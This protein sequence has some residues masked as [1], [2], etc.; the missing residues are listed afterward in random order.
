MKKLR[1]KVTTAAVRTSQQQVVHMETNQQTTFGGNIY[2][3][4]NKA[5][6]GTDRLTD[7]VTTW[8]CHL[9]SGSPGCSLPSRGKLNFVFLCF[10]EVDLFCTKG[11]CYPPSFV[12]F[13]QPATDAMCEGTPRGDAGESVLGRHPLYG[14]WYLFNVCLQAARKARHKTGGSDEEGCQFHRRNRRLMQSVPS[15]T[16][17]QDR[18]TTPI[19]KQGK[20]ENRLTFKGI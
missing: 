4:L 14:L 5:I 18:T 12:Y 1:L 8:A 17:L 10:F 11:V 16:N 9:S 13:S 20:K 6:F 3:R 15:Q 7:T 19:K 2:T